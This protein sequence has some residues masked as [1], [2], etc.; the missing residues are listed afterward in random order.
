MLDDKLLR[1]WFFGRPNHVKLV[2]PK[3]LGEEPD[4]DGA[5][6]KHSPDRVRAFGIG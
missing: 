3:G 5:N 6:A 4:F 1:A 2:A